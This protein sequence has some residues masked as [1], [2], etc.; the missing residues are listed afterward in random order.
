MNRK[1][2]ISYDG[3]GLVNNRGVSKYWGVS[4]DPNNKGKLRIV[5]NFKDVIY[6][7]YLPE[8][9]SSNEFAA[10]YI[11]KHLYQYHFSGSIPSFIYISSY[12]SQNAV[13]RIDFL[14]EKIDIMP[15]SIYGTKVETFDWE[16]LKA[17]V[18]T[19]EKPKPKKYAVK[20]K[21]D[22]LI[23]EM[24]DMIQPFGLSEDE[25]DIIRTFVDDVLSD[26]MSLRGRKVLNTIAKVLSE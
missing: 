2:N 24:Q 23:T 4:A 5:V 11:A 17:F 6:T 9:I 1:M 18:G 20:K 13:Y 16:S 22:S 12:T 19:D 3:I 15:K 7:F 21:D 26:R 8:E 25:E 10:A 14:N